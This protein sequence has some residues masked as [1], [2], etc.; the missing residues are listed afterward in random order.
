M[1]SY[2]ERVG[3]CL[4]TKALLKFHQ[5]PEGARTAAEEHMVEAA[6]YTRDIKNKARI[7]F[8]I[9]PE[10][11][12]KF[13]ELFTKVKDY[14]EN[15][16]N[17]S[18]EISYSF[19][20]PST[21]TIAVDENNQP[22]RNQEGNL[23][24]RPGGHGALLENL[25][26]LDADLIFIKNIDNIVPD[27]LKITTYD[28]KKLLG[29]YL[30]SMKEIISGF[31]FKIKDHQANFQELCEMCMFAKEK[32]FLDIP[33]D[34]QSYEVN[35]LGSLLFDLLN[36]PIRVCGMVKNDGEPGG[37]PFWVLEEDNRISLQIVEG[38]QINMKDNGQKTML[39]ASTHFNPVDLVCCIKDFEGNR[40]DLKEFLNE[41]TGFISLKSERGKNTESTGIAGALERSNGQMDYCF[42]RSPLNNI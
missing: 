9:S 36:R 32:L 26:E 8:T 11:Q 41:N 28:N 33:P 30:L 20:K 2:R 21:D 4:F 42:H 15:W 13:R 14:Y 16:L 12:D 25:N 18:F 31:L 6:E 37:G 10:H 7:H 39:E 35:D 17:V 23:L 29:G 40:F 24:F 1:D 5:Y 27:R 19:Q 38:S 34:F 22:V 3:L